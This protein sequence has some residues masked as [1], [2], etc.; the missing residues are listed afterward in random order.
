[1]DDVRFSWAGPY[2]DLIVMREYTVHTD[3]ATGERY[4]KYADGNGWPKH[5]MDA[6]RTPPDNSLRSA[7]DPGFTPRVTQ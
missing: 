6:M 3:P 4:R 5:L 1:M 7:Y 2:V